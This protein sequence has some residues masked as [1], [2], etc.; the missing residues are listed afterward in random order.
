[1]NADTTVLPMVEIFET[2]EGEGSAVGKQTTF[3]RLFHCNLRCVWCD[4]KYSY[5]PSKPE[6][7]AT[8]EDIAHK[9]SRLANHYVCL[10]GGEPLIHGEK[11]L[12]LI[13][14]LANIDV[15]KDIH[16]ETNGAIH[17]KPFINMRRLSAKMTNKVRFIMDFKLP[18]SGE[19]KKMIYEN[20]DLLDENDEIKFVIGSENDFQIAMGIIDKYHKKGRLLMSPI[21]E[22]MKPANLVK[23][24]L[25]SQRK[26]I[27]VNLQIHK[28][29]WDPEKRGV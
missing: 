8:L 16:I 18:D 12:A 24:V 13:E 7:E 9:V 1:M 14:M 4:T 10:T 2:I 17:L 3:I 27:Q 22:T 29:I 11:S 26:D 28:I 21:W 5:A 15:I 19:M 6:F 20:F 23:K 25:N